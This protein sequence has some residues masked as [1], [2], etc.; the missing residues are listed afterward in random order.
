MDNEMTTVVVAVI[1][2]AAVGLIL[3]YMVGQWSAVET[4]RIAAENPV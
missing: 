4:T 2:A 1:L 3:Y